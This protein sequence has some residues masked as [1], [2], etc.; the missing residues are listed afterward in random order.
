[1]KTILT[2]VD[3]SPATKGVLAAASELAAAVGGKIVLLHA[4]Q[5]PVVTTEYGLTAETLKETMEVGRRAALKQLDHLERLLT[6]KGVAA[7][8]RLATGLAA[9][10]IVEEARKS[11]AAYVVLGSHGHTA[12]Y[13]L[14]VGGTTHAV[15]KKAS[16]PVL[17]VPPARR[18]R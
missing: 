11:R 8:S 10:V 4:L 14:L 1:M 2:P 3:F 13:E 15:L 9:G 5:H 12:F 7:S 17:V 16:C 18:K 6:G